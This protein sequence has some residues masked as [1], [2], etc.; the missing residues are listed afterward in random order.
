[1]P[2]PVQLELNSDRVWPTGRPAQATRLRPEPCALK[3]GRRLEPVLYEAQKITLS[4]MYLLDFQGLIVGSTQAKPGMSLAHRREV[5]RA[6]GGK[7]VQLLRRRESPTDLPMLDSIQRSAQVRVNV[8]M[9]V[10][11]Q[12]RVVGAILLVRTPQGLLQ[13]I[14]KNR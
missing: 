9:P 11:G 8:A 5:R 1:R 4:G 13:A 10:I 3:V 14:Y 6:L 2:I 7:F 12:G